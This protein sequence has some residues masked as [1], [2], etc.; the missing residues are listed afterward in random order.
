MSF[1]I[2]ISEQRGVR[3]LHFGSS[4]IQGAMRI[5][6]PWD[7]ELAYTREM[8]T[9]L[10][11]RGA[12][13]WPKKVLQIGLGAGSLTKFLYRHHPLTH[14]T[15][16]EIE[17]AVV[18]VASQFFNL[19]D[20]PGRIN[21]KVHDGVDYVR[22]RESKFDLILVDA[23]DQH[24]RSGTFET[25]DFYQTCRERLTSQGIVA[26]NLL[27]GI[28]GFYATTLRIAKAFDNRSLMFPSCESGNAI[29]LAVGGDEIDVTIDELRERALSMKIESGLNLLPTVLRLAKARAATNNRIVL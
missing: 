14:L 26:I 12:I 18:T 6:R 28:R 9:A 27:A 7:L 4:W 16:V 23:F 11:L 21:I 1:P 19:P 22:S 17:S 29:A 8:M 20:D 25:L 24:A 15:V 13:H 10:L 2:N 5:S 3:Y